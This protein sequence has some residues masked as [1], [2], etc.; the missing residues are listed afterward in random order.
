MVY[1]DETGAVFGTCGIDYGA[2]F[3][4]EVI[5][6]VLPWMNVPGIYTI[7]FLAGTFYDY[8]S[9]EEEEMPIYKFRYVIDPKLTTLKPG[10]GLF[11]LAQTITPFAAISKVLG[12][13]RQ[14][15]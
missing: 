14:E 6:D 10:C 13:V 1:N 12:N 9:P 5:V 11:R 15:H 4:R 8:G 7:E 3:G 2:N